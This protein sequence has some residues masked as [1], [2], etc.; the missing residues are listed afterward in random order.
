MYERNAYIF[1][2]NSIGIATALVVRIL[3][4]FSDVFP[5]EEGL[6]SGDFR[7]IVS[8]LEDEIDN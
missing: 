6:Q 1:E 5:R 3:D 7:R 8:D 4:I 2:I